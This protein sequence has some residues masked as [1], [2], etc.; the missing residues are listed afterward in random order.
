[1]PRRDIRRD[2]IPERIV[3]CGVTIGVAKVYKYLVTLGNHLRKGRD[4]PA[5]VCYPL[6]IDIFNISSTC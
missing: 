1:V 2:I 6:G 5:N 3:E 4:I